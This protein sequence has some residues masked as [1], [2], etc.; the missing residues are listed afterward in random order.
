MVVVIEGHGVLRQPRII[1]TRIVT[2]YVEVSHF[3]AD[4]EEAEKAFAA[5]RRYRAGGDYP[6][7][8]VSTEFAGEFVRHAVRE[9]GRLEVQPALE[10]GF[11]IFSKV[12]NG[13]VILQ[14]SASFWGAYWRI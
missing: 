9:F 1:M 7:L 5:I 2:Q 14:F 10:T 3:V 12:R 11:L 4:L 13:R 6:T 8:V